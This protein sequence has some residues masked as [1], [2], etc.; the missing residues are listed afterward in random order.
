MNV[1]SATNFTRYKAEC[2]KVIRNLSIVER[3]CRPL[4]A[5]GHLTFI[6]AAAN[7]SIMAYGTVY[8]GVCLEKVI[9][10]Y[11]YVTKNLYPNI[12]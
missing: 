7:L 9:F 12:K 8:I 1:Y 2:A 11:E 4:I 3:F 5:E 6:I 10:I